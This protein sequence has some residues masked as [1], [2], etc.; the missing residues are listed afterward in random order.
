MMSLCNA[1]GD[2]EL[3]LTEYLPS[4]EWYDAHADEIAAKM[5]EVFSVIPDGLE[6]PVR[7]NFVRCCQSSQNCPQL[8]AYV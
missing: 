2:A 1:I 6:K 4:E 8:L 5:D 3:E 7:S